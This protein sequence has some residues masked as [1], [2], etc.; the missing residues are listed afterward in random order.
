[1]LLLLLFCF[2]QSQGALSA[3]ALRAAMAGM[4]TQPQQ[5]QQQQST[6]A[7]RPEPTNLNRVLSADSV[8]ATG[9]LND[10]EVR[11]GLI[12]LLPESQQ[13][14]EYL[15]E[16]LRSPQVQQSIDLLSAALQSDN[17]Q[18]VMGN[19]S[20]DP[21]VG[22]AQLMRGDAIGAFLAAAIARGNQTRETQ[23]QPEQQQQQPET[24]EKMEEEKKEEKKD[25]D[26]FYS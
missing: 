15:E 21:S 22:L 18:T 6:T 5:S 24:E 7:S 9:I 26:D 4:A 19:F 25:D 1:M 3:D 20:L 17:Y 16:T 14:E 2:S 10:P 12:A 8:L 13:S 11:R 23:P